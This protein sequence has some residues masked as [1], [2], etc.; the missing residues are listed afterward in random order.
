MTVSVMHTF[1]LGATPE[2]DAH[3]HRL[4]YTY[5]VDVDYEQISTT[6]TS[7]EETAHACQVSRSLVHEAWLWVVAEWVLVG[8]KTAIE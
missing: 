5:V 2:R 1:V 6:N 4:K 3:T 7:T 8:E